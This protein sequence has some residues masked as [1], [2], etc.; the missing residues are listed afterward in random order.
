MKRVTP[1]L[2][3]LP[4]LLLGC[5]PTIDESKWVG[6]ETGVHQLFAKDCQDFV[7]PDAATIKSANVSKSYPYATLDQV[8]DAAVILLMQESIIVHAERSQKSGLLA[9]FTGPP[10]ISATVDMPHIGSKKL[11]RNFTYSRPPLVALLEEST[12]VVAVYLYWMQGLYES[13]T[14]PRKVIVEFPEDILEK[15]GKELFDRLSTQ[16]YA[17]QKWNYLYSDKGK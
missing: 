14:E 10:F 3:L 1:I 2:V 6:A 17:R 9:T 5:M 15:E 4:V 16:I 12:N 7:V 11:V 8:W 13:Q